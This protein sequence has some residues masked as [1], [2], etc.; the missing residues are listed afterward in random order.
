MEYIK[1]IVYKPGSDI[2]P[3]GSLISAF[4]PGTW[5]SVHPV[6]WA[7]RSS[8][9]RYDFCALCRQELIDENKV[10]LL[11]NNCQ[12]FTNSI[13]H[14]SCADEFPTLWLMIEALAEKFKQFKQYEAEFPMWISRPD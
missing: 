13:V 5:C 6:N 2:M 3:P 14:Q 8:Y 7:P 12:L 4:E 9:R 10:L 1:Q 11:I